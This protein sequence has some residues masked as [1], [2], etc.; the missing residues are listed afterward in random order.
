M[1]FAVRLGG[2]RMSHECVDLD[3]VETRAVALPAPV[4][5]DLAANERGG[6]LGAMVARSGA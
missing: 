6:E 3:H 5:V 1:N 2:S 4:D